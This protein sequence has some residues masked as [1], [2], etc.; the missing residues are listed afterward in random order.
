[1]NNVADTAAWFEGI[2]QALDLWADA[3]EFSEARGIIGAAVWQRTE[4]LRAVYHAGRWD[5]VLE[6]GE[7][8]RRWFEEHGL[9]GQLDVFA[10]VSPAAVLVHR[11]EIAAAARHV[12]TLLP[13]ARESS[14]PQV[15]VPGLEAAALLAF[16]SGDLEDALGLIRELV[17]LASGKGWRSACLAWPVR[18]AAAIGELDLAAAF[19]DGSEHDSAWDRAARPGAQ[20]VLAEARG[21]TDQAALLYAE[22]AERWEAYGSVVERAYTLMGLARVAGDAKAQR[23]GEAIFSELGAAPVAARAA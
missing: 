8:V 6:E 21:A 22:A 16:T 10:N 11:G 18:I 19:L 13:A 2:P 9:S 14:D 4:R 23:E 17:E 5:E 15:L 12:E 1:M 7:E 3:I 20:A